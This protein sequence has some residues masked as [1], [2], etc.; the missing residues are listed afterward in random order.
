MHNPQIAVPAQFPSTRSVEAGD[1]VFA[2]ISAAFWD[3][4]GQVL[5]SFAVGVAP[6]PLYVELHAAADAAFDAIAAVL[7]DGAVPADVVAASGVIEQ[8]GFTTI[9]DLLHGYGGGYLPPILGTKSRPAGAV[10]DEPFKAGM[11]V[12][13]Q[14]NVVTPDGRAGVQTGEMV[15]ITTDGIERLHAMPRGFVTV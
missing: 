2:E 5:R 4:P 13:I 1:I 7:K 8:A 9:D 14:P 11:T 3:H 6:P 10:P 12:V 15:L